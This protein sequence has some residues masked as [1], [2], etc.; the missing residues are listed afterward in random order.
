[1][2][3]GIC[4]FRPQVGKTTCSE[5]LKNKHNIEYIEMSSQVIRFCKSYL[6]YN[7]NKK[8]PHQRKI[9]QEVG[10]LWK[11]MYPDIWI[12]HGLGSTY[13]EKDANIIYDTNFDFFVCL[14]RQMS[15]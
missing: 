3:I 10:H 9:L 14:K 15:F 1:M 4:S 6:G 13:A 5:Y 12:Y 11:S 8:D 2:I 7:G